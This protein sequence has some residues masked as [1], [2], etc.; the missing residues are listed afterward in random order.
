VVVDAN[1]SAPE[2]SGCIP[3][4]NN[5]D[6]LARCLESIVAQDFGDFELL[7]VDDDSTD[8]SFELARSL[9]GEN[10]RVLRN[11]VRLG[12]VGNHN[13]CLS[14]ARGRT[15]QFVHGDDRLLP[16][17][18]STLSPL[19]DEDSVG[20]AFAPRMIETDDESWRERYGRLEQNFHDLGPTNDGAALVLEFVRSGARG[21]W[22]GEPTCVMVRRS[23]ALAVG[24]LDEGIYQLVDMDLWMRIMQRSSVAWSPD[25]L[26]IRYHHGASESF[27]NATQKKDWLDRYRI[28]SKVVADRSL[29]LSLRATG[30]GWWWLVWADLFLASVV[31]GP[32][33]ASRA[34]VLLGSPFREL[35][36]AR[37]QGTPR[38]EGAEATV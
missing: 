25:E 26:S 4:Y 36:R 19:F 17:C 37:A 32:D 5:A 1:G 13:R 3:M 11:E 21:N 23:T 34:R 6:T 7:I 10:A 27:V 18:L 22:V 16:N 24:G 31:R 35:R 12:L 14:L 2:V 8:G 38:P 33:R 20:L 28:L 29:P 9:A 30:F 15:I